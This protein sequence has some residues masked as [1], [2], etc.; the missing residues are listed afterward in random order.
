MRVA[1][2]RGENIRLYRRLELV[3]DRHFNLLIG[4]NA[5]GK[6]TFLESI[7]VLSRGRSFRARNLSE[8]CGLEGRSWSVFT[9][10]MDES[11]GQ[12]RLGMGWNSGVTE[13]RID[14]AARSRLTEAARLFPVQLLE[15]GSHRL[16]EEGPA[17]RRAFVDWGVFHVE[18]RFIDY[19]RRFQRT[20][21]QRNQ[22]LRQGQS[23]QAVQVWNKELAVTSEQLT[24]ARQRHI[25]EVEPEFKR[26]L[27]GL[28][29][30]DE[31]LLELSQGW[32]SGQAY[33]DVLNGQIDQ[34]RRLGMTVQGPHR[35]ELKVVGADRSFRGAWS[36]GQQKLLIAA[37]TFAQ[38][39]AMQRRGLPAPVLLLDD[40]SSELSEPYQERFADLLAGYP[41]QL[42]VTAF[43]RPPA[44]SRCRG[45]VFHVEHSAIS[46]D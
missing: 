15:P 23:V 41:G 1:Q 21:K 30:Q 34:H 36:R 46:R 40:F 25:E 11:D 27:R 32:P 24:A 13:Y 45:A 18:H 44:L 17:Y 35:A 28:L 10:L 42:F 19:W 20:L 8:L 33:L 2:I 14:G 37:L 43:S 26:L 16:L 3:P 4:G 5:E 29:G 39:A 12:H 31:L 7:Y 38:A 9:A 22:A 6:T